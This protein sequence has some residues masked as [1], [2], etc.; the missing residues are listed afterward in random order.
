M[1]YGGNTTCLQATLADGS[2]LVLDAGTGIRSLGVTLLA[3]PEPVHVLLTHLHLDHIQGLMFFAPLFR[4]GQEVTIWGPG[5]PDGTLRDRIARYVSAPLCPVDIRDLPAHVTFKEVP[6]EPWEI[7]SATV[8]ASPVAHRGPTLGFRVQDSSASLC[9]LPDHEPGVGAP[10]DQLEDEWVSG[11]ELA[12]DASLLVHDSQYTDEEYPQKVGWGHSCLSDALAFARRAAA[13]RVLLFHHDPMHNDD[14]LDRLAGE[15]SAAWQA[16][17]GRPCDVELAFE[18]RELD[19][20]PHDMPRP[21]L[22]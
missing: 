10:L 7:G 8:S 15:A 6:P 18:L 4:R 16:A 2:V 13:R 19:L 11:L 17:G 14:F 1:R 21:A 12:R 5:S 22:R 20:S 9:F 3:R